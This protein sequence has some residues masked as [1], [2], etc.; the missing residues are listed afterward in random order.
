[1]SFVKSSPPMLDALRRKDWAGFAKRYNGP[2]YYIKGYDK[3]IERAYDAL[4]KER[5][6]KE[7][8]S[9]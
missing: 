7:T 9:R 3:S 6:N 2:A 5:A 1:V 8:V 4:V